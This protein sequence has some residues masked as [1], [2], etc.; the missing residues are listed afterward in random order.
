MDSTGGKGKRTS[1]FVFVFVL[2]FVFEVFAC[3]VAKEGWIA[4][5]GRRRGQA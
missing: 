2:L 1:I 4:R 5:G 3:A